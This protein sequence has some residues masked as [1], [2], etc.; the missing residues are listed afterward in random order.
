MV[1]KTNNAEDDLEV[2]NSQSDAKD[3]KKKV[4][5]TT[6]HSRFSIKKCKLSRGTHFLLKFIDI[7]IICTCTSLLLYEWSMC[8][9]KFFS[10]ETKVRTLLVLLITNILILKANLKVTSTGN[11][12]YLA[13]TVC[14]AYH[15][16]YKTHV[17]EEYGTSRWN[18]VEGN[19]TTIPNN[20]NDTEIFNDIT[21]NLSEVLEEVVASTTNFQVNLTL[22]PDD[23]TLKSRLKLRTG[24]SR[25]KD[26]LDHPDVKV[27]TKYDTNFGKCFSLE[28]G[29]DITALGVT[30]LD[31]VFR[32]NAFIYLH[33]PGQFMDVDAQ[34]KVYPK[35]LARYLPQF[36]LS[37]GICQFGQ[38]LLY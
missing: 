24:T 26:Q 28:L 38:A 16:A 10:K 35:V 11:E 7:A 18:Y 19:F 15:D 32:K 14:P 12:T 9:A 37:L 23:S 6:D 1:S 20:K 29:P 27:V 5:E 2:E 33:H 21:H 34:T 3:K 4:L 17:L 22:I 31:F 8:L 13:F 25:S 30:R 36:L